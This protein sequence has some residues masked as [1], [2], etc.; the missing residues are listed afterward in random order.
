M[1]DNASY[2]YLAYASAAIAVAIYVISL[3]VRARDLARRAA[4]LDSTT[5]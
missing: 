3:I 1:P 5:R 4:A 2:A